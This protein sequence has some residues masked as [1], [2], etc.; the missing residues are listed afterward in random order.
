LLTVNVG[1]LQRG[2]EKVWDGIKDGCGEQCMQEG[3]D[4]DGGRDGEWK[5]GSIC[6]EKKGDKKIELC[7]VGRARRN[8]N[9]LMKYY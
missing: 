3:I 6:T 2:C 7:I 9:S 5:W 4:R 8:G 1:S